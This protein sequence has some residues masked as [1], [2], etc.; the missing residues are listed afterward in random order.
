MMQHD[1]RWIDSGTDKYQHKLLIG[2]A[3]TGMVR[4]EWHLCRSG[5]LIPPNWSQATANVFAGGNT[6]ITNRFPIADAQNLIVKAALDNSYEW[7]FFLEHDNLLPPDTFIRLNE[8]MRRGDVPVMSGL[9]YTRSR[10][11]EP[12]LYRGRGTSYYGDWQL[13]D[14]V[15]VDGVPTGALLV[16]TSILRAMW[17]ES[18]EYQVYGQKTRKVFDVQPGM[19]LD[20]ESQQY[21]TFTGTSD[22]AWCARV[23]QGGF[24]AKA[25]W[26][27]YADKEYPFL[28]DTNLFVGH[29]NPNGEQFP[30]PNPWEHVP[31]RKQPEPEPIALGI[32]VSDGIKAAEALG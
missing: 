5:Q 15:W 8:Y 14:L 26:P 27:E 1:M 16:H 28:V 22:L 19:F 4:M 9:Y 23:M 25:G 13:G 7:L 18:E 24:F 3:T 31:K 30:Y 21:M 29:I 11:S 20:P 12:V 6:I 32:S 17:D 10:P 2:T